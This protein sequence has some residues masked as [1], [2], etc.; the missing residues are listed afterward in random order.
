[1]SSP[2]QATYHQTTTGPS[3]GYNFYAL[4]TIYGDP[5]QAEGFQLMTQ[6]DGFGLNCPPRTA[7]QACPYTYSPENPN[8]VDSVL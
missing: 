1:M 6:P 4:S 5:L 8:G 2:M 7:G 3:P